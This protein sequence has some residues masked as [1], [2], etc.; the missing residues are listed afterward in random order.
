[1]GGN[2][3]SDTTQCKWYDVFAAIL[4]QATDCMCLAC[5]ILSQKLGCIIELNVI[6]PYLHRTQEIVAHRGD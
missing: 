4:V 6:H 5:G 3:G 2:I 1:M